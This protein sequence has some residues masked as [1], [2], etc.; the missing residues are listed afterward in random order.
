MKKILWKI[1]LNYHGEVH[2]FIRYA[3]DM[4]NAMNIGI[5]ALE[6]KLCKRKGSLTSYFIDKNN[7][8]VTQV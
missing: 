6:Y 5:K 2:E 7:I 8:E 4:N 1:L 3:K